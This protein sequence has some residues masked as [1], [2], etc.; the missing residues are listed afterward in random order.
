MGSRGSVHFRRGLVGVVFEF[1]IHYILYAACMAFGL[2]VVSRLKSLVC[3]VL[4]FFALHKM[5][6][7]LA[8]ICA[9]LQ[10]PVK[11]LSS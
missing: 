9:L 6:L 8:F 4:G 1:C 2:S 3:L 11:L 10:D 5:Y 7:V